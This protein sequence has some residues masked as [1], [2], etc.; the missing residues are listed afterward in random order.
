MDAW[1]ECFDINAWRE[2]FE[3]SGIDGDFYATRKRANDEILPWDMITVGSPT[4]YL[5][6]E[7]DRARAAMG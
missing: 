3:Q 6:K 5:L 7:Q 4:H 1:S 2:V